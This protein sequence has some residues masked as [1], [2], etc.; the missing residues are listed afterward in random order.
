MTNGLL[1][2]CVL[3]IAVFALASYATFRVNQRRFERRNFAGV[4]GFQSYAHSVR[5]KL[6]EG[7]VML[8]AKPIK[9]LSVAVGLIALFMLLR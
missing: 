1:A 2:V 5:T 8:I 9:W 3:A 7:T 6:F 4:E